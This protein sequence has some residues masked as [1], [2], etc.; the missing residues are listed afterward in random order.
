LKGDRYRS[1][2]RDHLV[3]LARESVSVL[4]ALRDV[5]GTSR[6]VFPNLNDGNRPIDRTT[7]RCALYSAGY[8][9]QHVPHGFRASFST[10]MNEWA[11]R[12]GRADDREV[13]NL[14]LAHV[15][16]DRVER[17]YNR[18]L[19]MD[20]R[21]ELAQVWA[22]MISAELTEPQALLNLPR[23]QHFFSSFSASA[24]AD[25]AHLDSSALQEIDVPRTRQAPIWRRNSSR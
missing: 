20:R 24:V 4:R 18:A 22:T 7:L 15:P 23:K 11:K 12:H 1:D 3:P 25:D 19:Y 6:F 13:I 9:R 8:G 14:M 21:R 2:D 16:S 5:N 17:A 10:I